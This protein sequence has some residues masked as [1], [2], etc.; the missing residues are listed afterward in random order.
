MISGLYKNLRNKTV[1]IFSVIIFSVIFSLFIHSTWAAVYKAPSSNPPLG[2][3]NPPVYNDVADDVDPNEFA[4]INR[5]VTIG[6][7]LGVTGNLTSNSLISCNTIDTDAEGKLVCGTDESGSGTIPVN[8]IDS[9]QIIDESLTANDLAPNSVGTSEVIDNSLTANDLAAGSVGT[10]EIISGQVQRRLTGTC[11]SGISSVGENGAVSCR[12]GNTVYEGAGWIEGIPSGRYLVNITGRAGVYD[13]DE[14]DVKVEAV[15]PC[16]TVTSIMGGHPLSEGITVTPSFV[17][18]LSC[19]TCAT[20]ALQDMC[21]MMGFTLRGYS[22][23]LL[24][25]CSPWVSF[26]WEDTSLFANKIFAVRLN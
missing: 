21:G 7:F 24:A 6:G 3:P 4:Q 18:N 9:S 23:F 22:D 10:S 15:S 11:S 5:G 20:T 1:F 13:G 14:D 2:G 25:G 17:L 12:E 8:S 19:S 16:G 26:C